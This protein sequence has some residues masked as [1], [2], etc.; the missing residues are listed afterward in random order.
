MDFKEV[1]ECIWNDSVPSMK[2]NRIKNYAEAFCLQHGIVLKDEIT[3]YYKLEDSHF[4]LVLPDETHFENSGSPAISYVDNGDMLEM[5]NDKDIDQ[6]NEELSSCSPIDSQKGDSVSS[7]DA[8]VRKLEKSVDSDSFLNSKDDREAVSLASSD[9][10]DSIDKSMVQGR[11]LHRNRD[12][13][14]LTVN[15]D[16]QEILSWGVSSNRVSEVRFIPSIRFFR[17]HTEMLFS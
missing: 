9:S 10:I 8:R 2:A 1:N 11:R 7:N 17:H 3:S 13:K 5:N 14:P 4:K 15:N 16:K 6:T 12:I